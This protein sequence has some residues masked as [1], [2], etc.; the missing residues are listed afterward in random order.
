MLSLARGKDE[1]YLNNHPFSLA[2]SERKLKN[3][4]IINTKTG[5]TGLE[6]WLSWDLDAA[7]LE[8]L[9]KWVAVFEQWASV[10]ETISAVAHQVGMMILEVTVNNLKVADER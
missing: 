3:G 2:K 6:E 1:I 9:E 4:W 10:W 8:F 7:K 5:I